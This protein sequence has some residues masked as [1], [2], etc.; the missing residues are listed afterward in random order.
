[1]KEYGFPVGPITLADEVGVDVAA[2]VQSF[3]SKAD[4]GVRMGGSDGPVLDA[5]MKAKMLGRKT[6]KGF[7]TYPAGGKKEKGPRTLNP[8]AMELIKKFIKGESKLSKEEVQNRLVSRFVNEAVFALQ[9]G[10]IAS[11][12]EGD[13]GAVFGI[14]FPPFLGG[15]FRLLDSVGVGKYCTMLEG[16]AAKYGEQFAPA[17]LLVEH[18]KSEKKFHKS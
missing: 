11:P 5:L 6:G 17:P 7:Y 4:L 10:V 1:M 3:L 13:I 2:H 15:P 14:G 16:F 12:V 18:A 9:D 8:E